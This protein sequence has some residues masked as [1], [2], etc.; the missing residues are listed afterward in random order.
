MANFG[1]E[2]TLSAGAGW[3]NAHDAMTGHTNP[4]SGFPLGKGYFSENY[5]NSLRICYGQNRNNPPTLST[6][7]FELK[8][9]ADDFEDADMNTTWIYAPAGG[10]KITI[11]FTNGYD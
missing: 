1:E 6:E 11:K 7:G 5:G 8:N 3:K 2:V 10:E 9:G 4:F